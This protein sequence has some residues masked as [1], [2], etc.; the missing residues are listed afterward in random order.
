MTAPITRP[1]S[2]DEEAT[3]RFLER[4]PGSAYRQ[5]YLKGRN[6]TVGNLVYAMRA[7]RQTAAE[8]A[9][10]RD[11]P[12][13]QV[14]EALRYYACHGDIVDE[15]AREDRRFLEARGIPIDPP[16]VSR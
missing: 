5:L 4:R 1:I 7:N 2:P 9:E 3:Y 12:L 11:L 13:A 14:E 16:T 6:M 10:D 8:A 15:D